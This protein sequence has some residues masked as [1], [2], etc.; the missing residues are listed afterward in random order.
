MNLTTYYSCDTLISLLTQEDFQKLGGERLDLSGD[1]FVVF[2]RHSQQ[3]SHIHY[4]SL[5]N[6]DTLR[7][8]KVITST[9]R[10]PSIVSNSKFLVVVKDLS[11]LKKLVN[12]EFS[13]TSKIHYM[14]FLNLTKAEQKTLLKMSQNNNLIYASTRESSRQ[15][16]FEI[17]GG[18]LFTGFLLGSVFLLGAGV[19]I[20][21]KQ[22]SEGQEDKKNY[23]ILQEIGLDKSD[24]KKT[25]NSQIILI[26]FIPLVLAIIHFIFMIPILKKLLYVITDPQEDLIYLVSLGTIIVI[27]I[28][29]YSIYK[30]TSRT[31]YKLVRRTKT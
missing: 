7:Q 23:Q 2:D 21:Y 30:L 16:L 24:V 10:L 9:P 11:V 27:L 20:Y 29:Y 18:F 8:T 22:L 5:G 15:S 19:I 28:I 6:S 3:N 14:V 26:F 12:T 13:D 31:Y 17:T 25:I 1:E 4:L